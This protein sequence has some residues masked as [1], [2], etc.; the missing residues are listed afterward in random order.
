MNVTQID[1]TMGT[2][3]FF[4]DMEAE[5]TKETFKGMFK[6]KCVLNPLEYIGA[7]AMYRELLG[8]TNP[9]YASDYV[10]KLCYT[11][12]QLKYRVMD[13]PSWFK[14]TKIGVDGG[15]IDDAILFFILDKAVDCEIQFREGVQKKYEEARGEVRKAIDEKDN[16]KSEEVIDDLEE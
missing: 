11:I 7:D 12:S 16:K 5:S 1:Y 6:V 4:V 14:N 8:K 15:H 9:Q 3:T 10:S 13:S 2:A